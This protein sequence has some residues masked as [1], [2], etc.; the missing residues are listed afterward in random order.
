MQGMIDIT[1][2]KEEQTHTRKQSVAIPTEDE[3]RNA[4]QVD[5]ALIQE[6]D[7]TSW[8]GDENLH[9]VAEVTQLRALRHATID[10]GEP[11]LLQ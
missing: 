1:D 11:V 10:A 5:D 2:H 8:R 4:L 3:V 7:E 9:T 6:V